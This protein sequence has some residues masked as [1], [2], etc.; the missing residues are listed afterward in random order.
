MLTPHFSELA[1]VLTK[2]PQGGA[3]VVLCNPDWGTTVEHAHQ[4]FLFNHMTVGR[5]ELP[6][7]RM[8]DPEDSQE[9]IQAPDWGSIWAIVEGSLHPCSS[10]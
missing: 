4:R 5:I 8:Y 9:T 6:D 3:Q 2:F 7:A 10:D 1:K